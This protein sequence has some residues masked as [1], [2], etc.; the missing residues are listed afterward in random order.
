M[1]RL[2]AVGSICSVLMLV[3][4]PAWAQMKVAIQGGL[5]LAS[6]S[7]EQDGQSVEGLETRTGIQAGASLMVP[8]GSAV[9][10]R[11]GAG[12]IQRG[13]SESEDGGTFTLELDYINVP[14][15]VQINVPVQNSKVTPH[16]FAG[17]VVGFETGCAF[18]GDVDGA[19]ASV[20]CDA[21]ELGTETL[22]T[23]STSLDVMFG[24]GLDIG[25]TPGGIGLVIDASYAL[26]LSNVADEDGVDA[27]H[28]GFGVTGGITIP[29]G[30]PM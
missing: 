3:A 13:F 22:A 28:R 20:D 24:G 4:A 2:V 11:F 30:R 1:R 14:V 29:L 18:S 10:V 12:Y 6:M 21:S 16:F 25:L 15:L 23:K 27:K 7:I 26:G 8:V 9:A 17:G 19:S 5:N